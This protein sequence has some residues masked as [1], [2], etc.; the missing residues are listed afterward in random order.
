MF[1]L[2]GSL[3]NRS[4]TLS[5][6]LKKVESSSNGVESSLN[7]I[8]L[9][10]DFQTTFPVLKKAETCRNRLNTSSNFY[11]TFAQHSFDICRLL[12]NEYICLSRVFRLYRKQPLFRPEKVKRDVVC[13]QTF[14]FF[15]EDQ[16]NERT[17]AR[18]K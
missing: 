16:P 3:M 17:C 5:K 6:A 2:L 13:P 11:W 4:A 14:Y 10:P 15:S 8:K 7:S 12:S 18:K 1:E 9:L